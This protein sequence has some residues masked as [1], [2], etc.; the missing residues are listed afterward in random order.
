MW[1]C[2]M[3]LC[4]PTVDH[5]M[6]WAYVPS[7]PLRANIVLI[8]PSTASEAVDS[9]IEWTCICKV[10]IDSNKTD[11]FTPCA[12]CEPPKEKIEDNGTIK[13]IIDSGASMAFTSIVSDFCDLIYFKE[14]KRPL[15]TTANANAEILG[16][17]TVFIQT[18][19]RGNNKITWI[20]PVFY[21]PNMTERLLS[22]GQL[23]HGNLCIYGDQNTLNC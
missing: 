10:K 16:F 18:T 21:L 12:K 6:D 1:S 14:N 19:Q 17:G 11:L 13:W 15:V 9:R 2:G 8:D 23:L 22:M 7:F 20:N 4:R 5:N 3:N